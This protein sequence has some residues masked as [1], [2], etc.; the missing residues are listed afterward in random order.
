MKQLQLAGIMYRS[1][2]DGM[3]DHWFMWSGSNVY[4]WWERWDPYIKNRQVF[5]CPSAP[6]SAGDWGLNPPFDVRVTDYFPLWYQTSWWATSLGVNA[7][8]GGSL[9]GPDYSTNR[10]ASEAM[11]PHPAQVCTLLE[12]YGLQES[13]NLNNGRIGYGGMDAND[14][15]TYRHNEGW[16]V[17]FLDGHVKWVSCNSFWTATTAEPGVQNPPGRTFT[18]WPGTK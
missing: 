17:A 7:I 6:T 18:W 1:D 2:Y 4:Y 8:G 13:A 15:R 12:G 9:C 16:N 3:T 5:L 14:R 10:Y 11:F